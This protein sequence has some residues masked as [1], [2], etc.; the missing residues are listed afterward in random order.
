M[1]HKKKT[2]TSIRINDS[3]RVSS[4]RSAKKLWWNWIL[5]YLIVFIGAASVLYGFALALSLPLKHNTLIFV[6]LLLTG[7]FLGLCEG[8][9][10]TRYAWPFSFAF[11]TY[12][13]WKF[14]DVIVNG[15]FYIENAILEHINQY[16][17]L[18]LYLY[19]AKG[20][21][22]LCVTSFFLVVFALLSLILS[23][24]VW[25][26]CTRLAYLF[27]V[28]VIYGSILLLGIVP[29]W[30]PFLL[31]L[32]VVYS[33]ESMDYIPVSMHKFNRKNKQDRIGVEGKKQTVRVKSALAI[34]VITL[35]SIFLGYC[36]ISP[37]YY[38]KNININLKEQKI[39]MQNFMNDFSY[40]DTIEMLRNKFG[41]IPFMNKDKVSGGL[42]SGK[43][44]QVSKVEFTKQ[45]ALRLTLSQDFNWCYLKGYTG[46][47]YGEDH[48]GDLSENEQ[49]RYEKLQNKYHDK[50]NGDDLTAQ[51]LGIIFN[52]EYNLNGQLLSSVFNIQAELQ[53]MTVEHVNA[54]DKFLYAPYFVQHS[55]ME[56]LSSVGDQYF[57]PLQPQNNYE[58]S[59]IYR[60]PQ[61]Y[62]LISIALDL[63]YVAD[64][65]TGYSDGTVSS[66]RSFEREYRD[67]VYDVYTKLPSAGL[68]RL[69]GLVFPSDAT[70]NTRKLEMISNVIS[71]LNK[72]TNYSLSPGLVPKGEDYVEYFLFDNQVGY[73]AHYASSAVL[74][75]RNNGVPARYV[76][77]YIVTQED[78]NNGVY[79][80]TYSANEDGNKIV[81]IKDTNAHA[82]VEVYFDGIGWLPIEFT[83]GY[84]NSGISEILPE[85]NEDKLTPTA[86]IAPTNTP[87][88]AP[89][90]TIKPTPTVTVAPK[91]T[92]SATNPPKQNETEKVQETIKKEL[93]WYISLILWV[94]TIIAV[95]A[96]LFYIRYR[97]IW[98]QRSTK[99]KKG[100]YQRRVLA[101]YQEI[102]DIL[103]YLG[104]EK[105]NTT[106]YLNYAIEI[107]KLCP[108]LPNGYQRV[109]LIAL[110]ARFSKVEITEKEYSFVLLFYRDTRV[111]IFEEKNTIKRFFLRYWKCL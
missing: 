24:I 92:K 79:P 21:K 61:Y 58:I 68:S 95:I 5:E 75:L 62:D 104:Y 73:C 77:G 41:E 57:R 88:N 102:E 55:L 31:T 109:V 46:V 63:S 7:L 45:T 15:F 93:P 99:L 91:P 25:K 110:R 20:D 36:I 4:N 22:R 74:M 71:Y 37:N 19:V 14:I 47:A 87:T 10:V 56:G 50:F 105:R 32:L 12:V 29:P 3:I 52:S 89:T 103:D 1:G 53:S 40:E 59:N 27:L 35:V 90:S 48:W 69:K 66:I 26:R 81:D 111:R 13:I 96:I 39:K 9:K 78:M 43:I 51:F 86:T 70:G 34:C 18:Q 80:D 84:S 49:I 42:N 54:N 60:F 100:T 11:A 28:I 97:L 33:V 76:E 64:R 67:F 108:L 101:C 23:L 107:E 17:G 94:I 85:V 6:G 82:W 106:S 30:K 72:N 38:D 83:K 2:S 44:N 8:G 65:I 98:V 16:F